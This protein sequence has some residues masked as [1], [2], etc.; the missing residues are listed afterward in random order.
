MAV[1]YDETALR[2]QAGGEADTGTMRLGLYG[3]QPLGGFDLSADITDGF[4]RTATSRATGIGNAKAHDYGNIVAGAVQLSRALLADGLTLTPAAGVRAAVVTTGTYDETARLAAFALKARNGSDGSLAPYARMAV[5]QDFMAPQQ[6][7]L[8]P[9]LQAGVSYEAANPDGG[10]HVLAADGTEFATGAAHLAPVAAQF[11][12]GL[13]ARRANMS[14]VAKY[15]ATV[16]GNWT[17][18]TAE[19]EWEVRF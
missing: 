14:L 15:T 12:A 9:L 5:S 10:P 16:A 17:G 6:V 4:A 13:T 19:A 18:Q 2:D 1:G 8:T 11:G 3:T 7:T